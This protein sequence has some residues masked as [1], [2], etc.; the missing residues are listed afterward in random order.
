[1]DPDP[2]N[3]PILGDRYDELLRQPEPEAARS[4][5]ALE[6]YV[7]GSLNVFYH[8]TNVELSNRLVCFPSCLI[9]KQTR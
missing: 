6:L 1:A 3:M 7:S 5:S 8:R 2:A 4:A 9:S